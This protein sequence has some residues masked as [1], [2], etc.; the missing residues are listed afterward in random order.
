MAVSVAKTECKRD[1]RS[2]RTE[3]VAGGVGLCKAWKRGIAFAYVGKL[4][5]GFE[6]RNDMV[7]VVYHCIPCS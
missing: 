4:L 7:C 5:R 6:I 2:E 3:M 1:T